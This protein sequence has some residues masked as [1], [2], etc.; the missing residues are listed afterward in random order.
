MSDYDAV[1]ASVSGGKKKEPD[2]Y[3]V[4]MQSLMPTAQ[5]AGASPNAPILEQTTPTPKAAPSLF[6]DQIEKVKNY[7]GKDT[8]AGLVRGAGSIGATL[9]APVD[10]GLRALGLGNTPFL[11]ASDRR[12][13]LDPALQS[14]GA[15]PDSQQ[16]Q[17]AKLAAEALGT[18]GA[19]GAVA[20]GISMAPKLA[21]AMPTL[22]PAI[23]S[24]G[25]TAGGAKGIE[26][27]LARAIGG[28][29][30]GGATA[31]LINPDDASSGAAL[32][33]ALPIVAK[34]LG[35]AGTALGQSAAPKPVN[36][37]LRQT[38][39]D[40]LKAGFVIPPNM[41]NPGTINNII[42]SISG[43]QA[44]QQVFSQKN[45][46]VFEKL[47]RNAL[48]IAD[49]VPLS[50]GTLEGL[51]KTAGKAYADVSAISP[52]AAA[53]LEALKQAR[54]D[55]QAWYKSYNRSA[56]PIDLAQA[57]QYGATANALDTSL[58]AHA[59]QAGL[60]ELIPALRDARKQIAK[61]Y[62][63]ERTLNKSSGTVDGRVL[64]R[65]YEKGSPLSDGL[66]TA[67]QFASA[68][69]TISKSPQQ[70]GSVGTHNLKSL[71]AQAMGGTGLAALGP[72]GV[73]AG[74]MPFMTPML[75]RS[76]MLSNRAQQ[77]L[78]SQ[79]AKNGISLLGSMDDYL[80]LMYKSTPLLA[81]SGR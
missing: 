3:D 63:V 43:K 16:Y 81:N 29:V 21:A 36:P 40:S 44:T 18:A 24:G 66:E 35:A 80:P 51:R 64:G 23:Q 50:Q 48:G 41:V 62:T 32:G 28:A 68:F 13:Q 54:N 72:F 22:F 7:S 10:A 79:P 73:A 42:E 33:G 25:M 31:G 78:L 37:V 34:T 70:I 15:N 9:L 27:L 77:G 75:A 5:P 11:G 57:K 74:V 39:D 65:M 30:S 49:D 20:R 59:E 12:A 61:T 8:V 14:M 19:G 76:S 53:D 6:G 2:E 52:Q 26:G 1:F 38:I 46:Q 60:P 71:A 45:T 56:S 58:E 69:P 47:T 55:S 4:V 67:G 17:T